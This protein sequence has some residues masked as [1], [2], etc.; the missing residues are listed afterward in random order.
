MKPSETYQKKSG[1]YTFTI[2]FYVDEPIPAMVL[3]K[4]HNNE[5]E[6]MKELWGLYPIKYLVEKIYGN[7]FSQLKERELFANKY[8]SHLVEQQDSFNEKHIIDVLQKSLEYHFEV[9]TWNDMVDDSRLNE[10]E[11]YWAKN[12]LTYSV[13]K[14]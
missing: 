2:D 10:V 9:Y 12:H 11:N 7:D 13:K 3:T 4:T 5:T 14:I 8:L 1:D 6:V